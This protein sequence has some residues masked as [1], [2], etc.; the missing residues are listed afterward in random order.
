M[1]FELGEEHLAENR[2]EN[3]AAKLAAFGERRPTWH[4]IGHVQRNKARRVVERS[5]VLHSVDSLRLLE[6]LAHVA[7]ELERCPAVYLQIKLVNEESKSGFAP[8][9][10]EAGI[11]AALAS[12]H[13]RL[14]GL[15]TMAPLLPGVPETERRARAA[16]T[17]AQL[18]ELAD[19][20]PEL[21][22]GLS[23]GMT[24]DFEEA[25]A[26]G[27]TALRIGSAFFHGL[28]AERTHG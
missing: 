27:S 10:V 8:E 19:R 1:D 3:F 5:D 7:A 20:W 17:F 12:P 16:E 25:I 15:M 24:G 26:Q 4:Y 23:M 28:Q 22:L 14:A 18:R 6:H 2:L 9:V 21:G 11:E 13:V